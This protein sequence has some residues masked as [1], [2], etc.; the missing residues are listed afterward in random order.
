MSIEID[1]VDRTTLPAE[2]LPLAK[3]QMRVA[4]DKMD[5]YI[6][7]LI[8][9][10]IDVFERQSGLSIFQAT[11]MWSPD[12]FDTV[13]DDG[14][15]VPVQPIIEW[16]AATDSGDVTDQF[17][18]VGNKTG[19]ATG[20][21]LQRVDQSLPPS[22]DPVPVTLAMTVGCE[23]MDDIPL[24]ALQAILDRVAT[25]FTWREDL[26]EGNVIDVP[27]SDQTW[28]VGNWVPRV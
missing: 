1:T 4:S 16:T 27:Q 21:Y 19:R 17:K 5:D 24:G 3:E 7:G 25:L 22:F 20:L 18:I 28:F 15:L 12:S 13:N 9:R 14:V 10:T 8:A 11:L 23:A 6:T 26:A 2:M